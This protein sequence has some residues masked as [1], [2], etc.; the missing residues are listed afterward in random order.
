MVVEVVEH[1]GVISVKAALIRLMLKSISNYFYTPSFFTHQIYSSD[2]LV[3]SLSL[4]L[5]SR[6]VQLTD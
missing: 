1:L 6:L 5:V 3:R 2:S 4:S